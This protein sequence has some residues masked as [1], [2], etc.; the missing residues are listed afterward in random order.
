LSELRLFDGE[1]IYLY[2]DN[3][4]AINMVHNS[5]HHDRTKH[6]NIDKHF[7]KERLDECALKITYVKL[8][9]LL[10]LEH[11]EREKVVQ[12]RSK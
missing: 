11:E 7:I 6:I 1:P 5:V 3:Q 4:A 10:K 8:L 9:V 12:L 2:S